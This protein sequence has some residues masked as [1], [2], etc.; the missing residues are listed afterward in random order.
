MLNGTGLNMSHSWNDPGLHGSALA[1]GA[2][3]G[4]D[5]CSPVNPVFE[6]G[7]CI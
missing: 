6:V 5:Y 7:V 2:L 4:D 1:S 3:C